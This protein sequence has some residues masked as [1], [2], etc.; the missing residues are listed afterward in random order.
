MAPLEVEL[1]TAFSTNA[2]VQV[3]PVT[4]KQITSY[5]RLGLTLHNFPKWILNPIL[6]GNSEVYMSSLIGVTMD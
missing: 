3:W 1:A 6:P 4:S 2:N 5:S